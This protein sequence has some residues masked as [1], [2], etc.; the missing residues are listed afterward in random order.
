[1]NST[2]KDKQNQNGNGMAAETNATQCN[3]MQAKTLKH[4]QKR[5][6]ARQ[7]IWN[8]EAHKQVVQPRNGNQCQWHIRKREK[9]R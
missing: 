7:C 2:G 9:K 5:R 8:S 3:A 1:M 6:H 4:P